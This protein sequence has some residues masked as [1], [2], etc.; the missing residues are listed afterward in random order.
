MM[1]GSRDWFLTYKI[2]GIRPYDKDINPAENRMVSLG[3]LGKFMQ[4]F[5]RVSI[6]VLHLLHV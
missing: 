1:L 4:H 2:S 3:A 5:V 6:A